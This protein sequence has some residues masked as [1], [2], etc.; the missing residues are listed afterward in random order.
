MRHLY[1]IAI[2][3]YGLGL[4]IA[5]LCGHQKA[6]QM[7]EG[8]KQ[9]SERVAKVGKGAAWFHAASLGEFEQARPLIEAYRKRHPQQPILLTF[10]SPSGYEVRKGYAGAD[11]VCYLPLDTPHN[12]RRF[13]ET[14]APAVAFFVKY[15]IWYNYLGQLHRRGTPTYLFSAIFRPKQYFFRWWGQWFGK[16]MGTCYSH[17]FVQNN[18]SLRLLQEHG[19][20]HCS[21]A[22]DTRFDRVSQTVAGAAR[23]EVVE[24]W[25]E[26]TSKGGMVMVAGSSWPPDEG[27]LARVAE[28]NEGRLRM[29]VAPHVVNEAHVEQI[30]QL[31]P[32][33]IRYSEIAA[34]KRMPEGGQRT[35]IIDNVGKLAQLYRYGK[36]AYIGGGFG[37]GIHNIL[38][39]VGFGLPVVFGPNYAK[40]QEAHDILALGGGW[41]IANLDELRQVV[42]PKVAN[43]ATLEAPAQVCLDYINSHTGGTDTILRTIEA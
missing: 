11:A 38:E 25:L 34:E 31:F 40:F 15:D 42:A 32:H 41:T 17:V 19:I 37:V 22:A 1:T 16:Q 5:A 2:A 14:V 26:A 7:K 3:C 4:R 27:L 20:A 9:W 28:E 10:F 23:D 13:I 35:L 21:L 6:R 43:P 18:E 30:A 24:Q 39:A 12:A 8:W 33:S 29:I 36:L